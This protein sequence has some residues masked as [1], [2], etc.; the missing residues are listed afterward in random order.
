MRRRKRRPKTISSQGLSGQRG[1]NLIEH[2]ILEMG[3]RW[4]PSGPNEIGIDGYIE[5]FDPSSRLP[6]GLTLGA[7]S[8]VV[9][10]AGDQSQPSFDYWCDPNDLEYW[11]VGNTPIILVVSAPASNVAYWVSIKDHF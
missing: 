8:K 7:Q 10:S 4:T 3:S 9:E 1:V 5:L 2:I 6:L 11:L